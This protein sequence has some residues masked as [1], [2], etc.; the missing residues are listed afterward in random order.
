MVTGSIP[1]LEAAGCDS[2]VAK[3]V[4]SLVVWSC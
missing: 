1:W 2:L 3:Y 4:D